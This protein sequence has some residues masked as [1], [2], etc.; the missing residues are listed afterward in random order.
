VGV[1]SCGEDRNV[2]TRVWLEKV[3][4]AWGTNGGRPTKAKARLGWAGG[5]RT[6][7]A[8]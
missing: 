2:C 7:G 1:L 3:V 8:S 5:T 4:W 6:A